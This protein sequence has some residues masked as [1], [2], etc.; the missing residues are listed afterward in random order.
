MDLV[1]VTFIV[2]MMGRAVA[3]LIRLGM[4]EYEA[5]TYI[6]LVG[7]GEGTA[8][9][10]HEASGVPRPRI[11][12]IL[13]SLEQKGFVEVWQG[14]PKHYRAVSPDRLMRILRM[15]LE[16][17]MDVASEELNDLSLEARNKTF[18][19]WHVKG[20]L[21]ITDQIR[22]MF[23]DVKTELVVLCTKTS[24][25][26]S[27]INDLKTV[28]EKAKVI[29][30]VPEGGSTFKKVLPG[31]LIVEPHLGATDFSENYTRLFTSKLQTTDD[32]YRVEIFIVI[33]G[34][35]SL[36]LYEVNGEKTAIV[37]ELPII[38]IL[39]RSAIISLIKEA[40]TIGRS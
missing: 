13:E 31:V 11:Y 1:V 29:C 9:Q 26:R 16:E 21:S 25:F 40:E 6:G 30:M 37:F 17:S 32:I 34:V 27:L 23:D 12:D 15:G 38:T 36:L 22:T 2:T 28:S 5:R 4:G 35:R 7:L 19:V 33:D 3:E 39:Q 24:A 8:R 18:P 14:K 10:I 20:E